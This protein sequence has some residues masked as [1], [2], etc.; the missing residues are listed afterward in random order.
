MSTRPDFARTSREQALPGIAYALP[1]LQYEIVTAYK[2]VECPQPARGA[3]PESKLEVV[4]TPI[5][6]SDYVAAERYVI[7]YRALTNLLKTTDF[8]IETYEGSGTLKSLNASIEDKTG[9][10]VKAVVDTAIS[11]ATMLSGAP[12]A[13]GQSGGDQ[14]YVDALKA[15]TVKYVALKCTDAAFAKLNALAAARSRIKV[16]RA[17]LDKGVLTAETIG[18]R[19][20]LKMSAANDGADLLKL[21]GDQLARSAELTRL[22]ADVSET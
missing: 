12:I 3:T 5:A 15:A 7:D 6:A 11:G 9:E 10:V 16:L 13:A 20:A 17:E 18:A 14:A 8:A 19:A 2:I 4:V 22:Q 1:M 21:H